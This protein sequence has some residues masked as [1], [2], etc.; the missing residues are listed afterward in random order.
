MSSDNIFKNLW[1]SRQFRD[2]SVKS[3]SDLILNAFLFSIILNFQH[4][5]T[6]V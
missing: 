1:N 5:N 6:F 3:I 4:L 2:S